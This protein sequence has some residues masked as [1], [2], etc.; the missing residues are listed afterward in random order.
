MRD[1][2]GS[3][4]PGEAIA[5]AKSGPTA[6]A[7][8]RSLRA[9][10]R[11]LELSQGQFS[12]ILARCNYAGLRGVMIE[13]LQ[14]QSSVPIARLAL[15]EDSTTLYTT[16]QTFVAEWAQSLAGAGQEAQPCA[17]MLEGLDGVFN[18]S[19]LLVSTNQVR[20]E[21]RKFK[22]PLILW[23]DNRIFQSMGEYAIDFR[24][25]AISSK[26]ELAV[27]DLIQEI[28]GYSDR[29][30]ASILQ[31]GDDWAFSERVLARRSLR[32]SELEFALRDILQGGEP[33]DLA[34]QADLDFLLGRSVHA[35]ASLESAR[36]CYESSL[37]LWRQA[38][39]A[40]QLALNQR[41]TSLDLHPS[42]LEREACLLFHLGLCW[43]SL[44]LMQRHRYPQANR[45]AEICFRQSL[46]IFEQE[47]R[48]DLVARF[49]TAQEE[50]LQKLGWWDDLEQL[51]QRAV[52]LHQLHQDP[53]RRARDHGFLA[54]VGLA[55]GNWLLAQE[56]ANIALQILQ[57]VEL[58]LM[59]WDEGLA[60]NSLILEEGYDLAQR[61]HRGWY[62]LLLARAQA[63]LG[64]QDEAIAHLED[65]QIQSL[66]KD[67]PQLY[68]Q[69]LRALQ[70]LYFQG[71][72]YLDAFHTKQDQRVV[73]HQYGFRA[74]VGALKLQPQEPLGGSALLGPALITTTQPEFATLSTTGRQVDISQL[75]ARM[76]RDDCKLTVIHG[77]SGVGKSS[78]VQAGLV[79]ALQDY[80]LGN[81]ILM[82]LLV[83]R[84]TDWRTQLYRQ[85]STAIG[86]LA[87]PTEPPG[88]GGAHPL[89]AAF[90][91]EARN[92]HSN[93]IRALKLST[94]QKR[95]PVVIF[96]QFEE[97]FFVY[98]Q[99]KKRR[100]FYNFL[101]DCLNLPYVKVILSL[102]EDYVHYLLEFEQITDLEVI[103]NDILSKEIRY[104]LGDF[105]QQDA[106][107]VIH[108]LTAKAQFYLDSDLVEALVQD[109]AG[110]DGRVR[111]IELQVVGAQLQAENITTLAQYQ[112]HGPKQKL[113]E[114]SLEA[115]VRDCG[116]KNEQIARLALFLLTHDKG[117]RPLRTREELEADLSALSLAAEVGNLSLVL[118]VLVGSG[119]VFL[120]RE[121]PDDR[122]QLVHD[123]LV[124]FIRQWREDSLIMQ[125]EKERERRRQTE[126]QLRQTLTQEQRERR[127]AEVAELEAL[128]SLSQALWLA[129]QHLDSLTTS[130]QA[131]KKLAK[132]QVPPQQRAIILG[133][134]WRATY[135]I[136][137]LNSLEHRASVWDVAISPQGDLIASA[138]DDHTVR[139][140]NLQGQ[141]IVQLTQHSGPVRQVCFSPDGSVLVSA[142]E[143]GCVKGW[144]PQGQ[145]LWSLEEPSL[146][147]KIWSVGFSPDGQLLAAG[148]MDGNLTLWRGQTL[149]ASFKTHLARIYSLA[150]SPDGQL[151]A[152]GSADKTVKLWAI[153]DLIQ[154]V[155]ASPLATPPLAPIDAS[156]PLPQLTLQVHP[157][158]EVRSLCFNPTGDR[159]ATASKDRTIRIW[160]LEGKACLVLRGHQ[161]PLWQIA[162]S[163]DGLTLASTSDDG[164][165]KLWS[166]QESDRQAVRDRNFSPTPLQTL[167][168]HQATVR[169]LCMYPAPQSGRPHQ[170]HQPHQESNPHLPQLI[171]AS[172]DATVK[173][174]RLQ[175]NRPQTLQGH[176][177]WVWNASFDPTG[178]RIVT[179]SSDCTVKL[180]S[181][182]GQ[183]LQT[184]EGHT[185]WV[186]T[187]RF[188]PDGQWIASGG[189]DNTIRLWNGTTGEFHT[190]CI[191]HQ[192]GIWTL[193]FSPD[194]R[195]LASASSDHTVRLW[196]LQGDQIG[197]LEG[198]ENWV[199]GVNF[200]PN[201]Q[202]LASASADKTIKLWSP[203][204]NEIR[205]LKGHRD[206]VWTVAF[207]PNGE[208]LASASDDNTVKLWS[209]DGQELKTLQGH[210]SG[211]WGVCFS[212]DGQIVASASEDGTVRLWSL[213][214]RELHCFEG[215]RDWVWSVTFSPDGY[216]LLSASADKTAIVWEFSLDRLLQTGA[217][218]LKDYLAVHPQEEAL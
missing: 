41:A 13:Q 10:I 89:N 194:G 126:V 31:V 85:L 198:H 168:G 156:P 78:T 169:S 166:T 21:F 100:D 164:T 83:D 63:K 112:K 121:S 55:R 172:A 217:N 129:N 124:S 203:K 5:P 193:N 12:L 181:R 153:A 92:P 33:L 51:A 97:F 7:N 214:G 216:S 173:L 53:I 117:T 170:P 14:Q 204:G 167:E 20:D 160:N 61:F 62:L 148:S 58:Q 171:S 183:L 178:A 182:E 25:W 190:R 155:P 184:L 65:A 46:K 22:F 98:D 35:Q 80:R 56:Q 187:V 196:N 110:D 123:Y 69:I 104:P 9:L 205:T 149:V 60:P 130:L 66:P 131:G 186:R 18:L 84:Y 138:C 192:S 106:R 199:R 142:S 75:L 116:P 210:R 52:V 59:Q 147:Q 175:T 191:G 102:R 176:R 38:S 39:H 1:W 27:P 87:R 96:D 118:E 144:S 158:W 163:P 134:L 77:P 95:S 122:Y 146:K 114:R 157:D 90:Q 34:L 94:D 206:W 67:D 76:T 201:G 162:Y 28:R 161:A 189:A 180:W 43:R 159:L 188:S 4:T 82:P 207:S 113:V 211:V 213:D 125:L 70:Q 132:T 49:I 215:H 120:I 40:A 32:K 135:R 127:R 50:V 111:P 139:L 16:L 177:D 105:S 57:T 99:L 208:M 107:T 26:F 195:T 11:S 179:G 137:E 212:P 64:Q 6:E 8:G 119:L 71:D 48:Q 86:P 101:R 140:W 88:S 108:T 202:M 68:I 128:S 15:E 165:I 81:R 91:A 44:G 93:L 143:D 209:I 197:C 145:L 17:V 174:W 150:F 72:R 200:S 136:H 103:N 24:S 45:H 154:P 54:E 2:D 47:N 23:V 36:E 151:L 29:L 115:V 3:G 74:F 152:T 37:D 30:F 185:D 218:W 73:E 79:P 133:R 42:A 109:L 141:E 19:K